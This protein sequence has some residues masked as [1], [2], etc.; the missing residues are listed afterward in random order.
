MIDQ[1]VQFLQGNIQS[2]LI[3]LTVTVDRQILREGD[4]FEV[5]KTY[6]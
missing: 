3:R 4:V 5:N 2:G 6:S 1:L